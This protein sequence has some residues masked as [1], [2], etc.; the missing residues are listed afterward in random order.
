MKPNLSCLKLFGSR[1]C[2]KR[3]G[4]RRGKLDR[5]NFSNM[6]LGYAATDQ[7][8]QYIDL[9]SGII[10]TSHHTQFDKAWYLQPHRPPAANLLYNLGSEYNE[11]GDTDTLTAPPDAPDFL[12]IPWPPTDQLPITNVKWTLPEEC[13]TSPLPFCKSV[14]PQPTTATAAHVHFEPPTNVEPDPPPEPQ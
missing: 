8:M 4:T 9:T 13:Y 6:F 14:M 3:A 10:K 7:N 2:V 1:V 11:D 12:A 5:Y